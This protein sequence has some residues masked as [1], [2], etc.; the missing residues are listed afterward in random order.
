MEDLSALPLAYAEQIP[1]DRSIYVI[2]TGERAQWVIQKLRERA[3]EPK[4][5][6]SDEMTSPAEVEGLPVHPRHAFEIGKDD[7]IVIASPHRDTLVQEFA[8]HQMMFDASYWHQFVTYDCVQ[9]R[10]GRH[11]PDLSISYHRT[12]MEAFRHYGD[13]WRKIPRV[14][15]ERFVRQIEETFGR[16]T[17]YVANIGCNDGKRNDP[18]YALFADGW[19]GWAVDSMPADHKD[20]IAGRENLRFPGVQVTYAQYVTPHNVA[21]LLVEQGA[22]K[23]CD[24]IKI[25]IDS[26][27]GL[28]A[29]AILSAGFRPRV[30]C[31]ECNPNFPPPFRFTLDYIPAGSEPPHRS[32]IHGA[33]AAYLADLF[34]RFGYRFAR[35]DFGYP[36][37]IGGMRDMIF[38]RSDVFDASGAVPAHYEDAFYAEPFSESPMK[39]RLGIDSR[40]WRHRPPEFVTEIE[41]QLRAALGERDVPFRLSAYSAT[42]E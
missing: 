29:E 33:S 17:R 8:G 30:V 16:G 21:D 15:A 4:G 12:S 38:I 25:D 11:M 9:D 6:L 36:I 35:F 5:V 34:A 1:S 13:V 2:G 27:D 42:A 40:E 41:R 37:R 3:Y 28:V 24:F 10:A 31:I 39:P 26:Y 18:C 20:A 14:S 19:R 22:P 32:G 23:D 7:V